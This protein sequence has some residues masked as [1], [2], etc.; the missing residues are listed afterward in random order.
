MC[1]APS[2]SMPP[3]LAL[4]KSMSFGHFSLKRSL[5]RR[6]AQRPHRRDARHETEL[7]REPRLGKIAETQS[8]HIDCPRGEIHSRP[9]RPRPLVWRAAT[10]QSG[11]RSPVSISRRASSLVE[12]DLCQIEETHA[13]ARA[14][15]DPI[16]RASPHQNSDL[17]A[18]LAAVHDR[19][20]IEP[21]AEH[22]DR[23]DGEHRAQRRAANGR[24][25]APARR[26]T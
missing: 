25:P 18:A 4:S 22:G 2:S 6:S 19:R 10:I 12:V 16:A 7:R 24:R 23:R 26:N 21:E 14:Q 11:P 3:S 15:S 8:S 9:S 20:R 1:R 17:A 5:S 13:A